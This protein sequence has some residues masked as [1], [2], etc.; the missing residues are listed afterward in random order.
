[1]GR[2]VQAAA[3]RAEQPDRAALELQA[4]AML[5]VL[6][7]VLRAMLVVAAVVRVRLVA[8]EQ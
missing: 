6:A 1:V 5:A 7:T 2:V 3:A 4:K 8:L